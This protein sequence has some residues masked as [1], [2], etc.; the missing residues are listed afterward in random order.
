M[1]RLM[2]QKLLH[3]KW[4]VLCLLIGNVLLI[5]TA[6]S[7]PM[8]KNASLKRMLD[9]ELESYMKENTDCDIMNFFL[10]SQ[11]GSNTN[12]YV[13][14]ESRGDAVVDTI[15]VNIK[16]KVSHYNLV[17]SNAESLLERD[18][19]GERKLEIGTLSDFENCSELLSGRYG[20]AAPDENGC[21]EAVVT[22][23][24]LV[25]MNLLVGEELK[26]T[27]LKDA[28]GN[29]IRVKVVGVIDPVRN[30]NSS[31]VEEDSAF[32]NELLISNAAFEKCF[33]GDNF[34][35]SYIRCNWFYIF[36]LASIEVKKIDH[37]LNK[38]QAIADTSSSSLKITAPGYLSVLKSF[39]QTENKI[40]VTLVILQVPVMALLLAF[41]FMISGQMLSLEQNEISLL[42]S[43][44]ASK[45]QIGRL[46]LLQ[47]TIVD[48]VSCVI[49]LPIG[50]LMCQ[51]IGS[52]EAFLEFNFA[53]LLTVRL[54]V[55][56]WIYAIG[57]SVAS[58]L[59]TLIPALKASGLSIVKLKQK[60][61]RSSK[62]LWQKLY[63]DVIIFGISI[64]GFYTFSRQTDNL[65][66]DVLSG[67]GLD[68]LLYLSSVLFILGSG[69]LF[70]RIQPLVVKL[71]FFIGKKKWQPAGY[72]SFL[73]I[74]RTGSKQQFVMLFL[75]LTVSL[76]IFD[77]TVARTIISNAEDNATYMTADDIVLVEAWKSN[78]LSVQMDP[79]LE[80]K[81]VE[82]DFGKY[83]NASGIDKAAKV[84]VDTGV[85]F[86]KDRSSNIATL[87]AI[88]TK[89]FGEAVIFDSTLLDKH[90]NHY[91][92]AI[93]QDPD[94]ILCSRSFETMLNFKTGDKL[95]Y[96]NTD[97][98]TVVGVIADFVDYWPAF[99][100]TEVK[101]LN[102]GSAEEVTN[103]LIVAHLSTIQSEWGKTPY[104]VYLKLSD[105]ADDDFFYDFVTDNKVSLASYENLAD[106]KEAVRQDTLF[107]G[108]NGILTMSFIVILILCLAGYLIYWIMSIKSRELLFGVFRAMG[109]R[110]GEI[111][112]ML[113][114]EQLAT[115]IFSIAV[116]AG[117]GVAASRMFVP[118]IQLAY[119]GESQ[120]TPLRLT[121]YGSDMIRLFS[122]IFVMVIVS[123]VVLSRI[124]SS[125][126]ITN[127]L[128]LGED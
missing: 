120:V 68:P 59:V 42:K 24:C 109:M 4:M 52:S 15:G 76:G 6:T 58:I 43:R 29:N 95:T 1:F 123:I 128:K 37:V 20:A 74:I 94:A 23:D 110:K 84:F 79:T 101:L 75:V 92:N 28:S 44:G 18:D 91:L 104:R 8:Y 3:K 100:P 7:Y 89:E 33:L 25:E 65:V 66:N 56:V 83:E 36:D 41:L 10:S 61:A 122:V 11:N 98:K 35:R 86:K 12:G 60:K 53:R 108:T 40:N 124:V 72:A 27:Y 34:S 51:L 13:S 2:L 16:N 77:S 82:P 99:K 26:F 96:T 19:V 47:S 9:D 69:M 57:A 90:I 97:G 63:L 73:Q 115:G 112:K 46:Y 116:G 85:S 31:W 93:S 71:I 64:Y 106:K 5:A 125:M 21:I 38:T 121:I 54:S 119:A 49:G 45:H 102:D 30:G 81:Y 17:I 113:F 55:E 88:D 118:M 127:A 14:M 126:K 50:I 39:K 87:M 103:F 48:A 114:N 107:Q 117:I 80:L 67:K 32:S 78:I 105:K 62:K 111:V 22:T 70:L